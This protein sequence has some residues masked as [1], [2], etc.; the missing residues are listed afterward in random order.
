MRPR[1]ACCQACGATHVLLP[2]FLVPRRS[3][4]VEVIGEALRLAAGGA[5]HR[6]IAARLGRPAGTVRGWLR[7]FAGRASEIEQSARAWTRAIDIT[8]LPGRQAGSPLA[9]AVDALAIAARSCRLAL[10]TPGTPWEISVA[11]TGGLLHGLTRV[12]DPAL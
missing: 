3:D 7:A 11:L 1:R 8:V 2:S 10:R 6:R 5:G 12:P 9:D 4:T